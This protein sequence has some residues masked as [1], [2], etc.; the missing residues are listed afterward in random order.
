[1]TTYPIKFN[2]GKVVKYNKPSKPYLKDYHH[3]KHISSYDPLSLRELIDWVDENGE[4]MRMP[5]WKFYKTTD[6]NPLMVN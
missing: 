3:H 6:R 1:M 4:N 5:H 2:R